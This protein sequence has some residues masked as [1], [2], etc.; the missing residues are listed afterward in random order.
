MWHARGAGPSEVLLDDELSAGA[1]P[2][3]VLAR[4]GID[5]ADPEDEP[6]M[7]AVTD[8]NE[9]CARYKAPAPPAKTTLA[10]RAL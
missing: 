7:S 4:R 2:G 3:A 1:W 5:E 6:A 8:Q 10:R 9:L